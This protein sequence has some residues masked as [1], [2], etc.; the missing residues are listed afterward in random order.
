MSELVYINW[1]AV[2]E[3]RDRDTFHACCGYYPYK[4]SIAE[5]VKGRKFPIGMKFAIA[6]FY[7]TSIHYQT[8]CYIEFYDEGFKKVRIDGENVRIVAYDREDNPEEYKN[9]HY[10]EKVYA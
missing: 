4:G 9:V 7:T 3:S 2:K 6:D 8:K 5:V 1:S 10:V